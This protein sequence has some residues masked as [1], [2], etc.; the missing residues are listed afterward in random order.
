MSSV[1]ARGTVHLENL[2]SGTTRTTTATDGGSFTVGMPACP[3]DAIRVTV[4]DA[5]GNLDTANFV[6]VSAS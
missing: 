5:A 1:E 2:T 6:E 3:G 4:E